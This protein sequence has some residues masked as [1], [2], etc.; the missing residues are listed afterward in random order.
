MANKPFEIQSST[1][2][3]G[4]VDLQAGET[5]IVI[6]GVT[7]ASTYS[8]DE[9]NE[10]G[11]Q[12]RIFDVP[13]VVIDAVNYNI[14]DNGDTPSNLATYE[15]PEIDNDGHIDS[16]DVVT[17]GTA[18]TSVQSTANE[19][20]NMYAYIG[21]D[22]YPNMFTS[23]V[24]GDWAQIPFRPKMRPNAIENI[25]GG[26]ESSI[27]N[28]TS[29]VDI[30]VSD[31]S[32]IVSADGTEWTFDTNGN[33][34]VPNSGA[35]LSDNSVDGV[36]FSLTNTDFVANKYI[37]VR[38]GTNENYSHLH[39]DSGDNLNYDVFLGDDDKFVKVDHTGS[40]DIQAQLETT[41]TA[42]D[43]R[44]WYNIF[45]DFAQIDPS[46]IINGSVTYD[47][48]GYTYV[49]GST[50]SND[51]SEGNHL[52]LKYSP[53]G[54]LI[55]RKTWT[56]NAGMP[57]GSYNASMRYMPATVSTY[58][59][60]AVASYAWLDI[61][62]YIGT[63]DTDGN[64]VDLTGTPRAP[65]RI[66][67][68]KITDIEADASTDSAAISGQFEGPMIAGIDFNNI[69]SPL[70]AVFAPDDI[71]N[72][73]Y[74]KSIVNNDSVFYAAVGSYYAQSNYYKCI[75]GTVTFAPPSLTTALY[76][77]GTN[78]TTSNLRGEDI[79]KD[80]SGN[81]YVVING[82]DTPPD[83]IIVA[84]TNINN[85]GVSRWQKKISHAYN[86]R[87]TGLVYH[88]GFV[89]LTAEHST[90]SNNEIVLLKL[91]VLTGDCVWSRTFS[92]PNDLA[93]G[94]GYGDNSSSD[95]IV[96]PTGKYITI[97]FAITIDGNN[98]NLTVQY[99]L[100]GELTGT[101]ASGGSDE[102]TIS[103]SSFTF[104]F[105]DHDL[106]LVDI[107]ATTT[108]TNP[109]LTITSASLIATAVTV[110]GGW[111]NDYVPLT[112]RSSTWT[113]DADG[114][115]TPPIMSQV[116]YRNNYGLEG[117]TLQISND[118]ANQV[119]ITGPKPTVDYPAARRIV[120]QGRKG[121]DNTDDS[122][123]L[124]PNPGEGG[125]VY[126]WGGTGGEGVLT[127]GVYAGGSGGDI[128][129]RGGQGQGT[130]AGGYVRI[131]GGYSDQGNGG[132]I[133]ITAGNCTVDYI[134]DSN[135]GSNIG[136]GGDVNIRA[137]YREEYYPA[138]GDDGAVNVYTGQSHTNQWVFNP[139]GS[140]TFPDATVQTTAWAGEKTN[141]W[142]QDFSTYTYHDVPVVATSTEYATNGDI[143]ALF[144]HQIDTTTSSYTSLARF[145]ANGTQVW[146]M[147]FTI[148]TYTNGWGLAVDNANGFVYVAGSISTTG[149]YPVLTK[150]NQT[151]GVVVWSKSYDYGDIGIGWVVDVDTSGN[152][153]M[154]GFVDN[155]TDNS[156]VT[157]KINPADGTVTWS[158]TLDGQQND[159][160]YGMGVGPSSEIVVVGYAAN[161]GNFTNEVTALYAESAQ[162][163]RWANASGTVTAGGVT[164]NY[165]VDTVGIP[166]F[167][168]S[169]DATGDWT[170]GNTVTTILGTSFGVLSPD[171]DM[172][173]KV[174]AVSGADAGT[175]VAKYQSNG[176]LLWQKFILNRSSGSNCSGADADIDQYG[177]VY[178]CGTYGG[179]SGSSMY[180]SKF[181][182]NG[183]KLW[184]QIVD[185]TCD[186]ITCSIVVGDDNYLYMSGTVDPSSTSMF[187]GKFDE[188]GNVVWQRIL[189]NNSDTGS[190]NWQYNSGSNIAV[191]NG[192]I[193]IGG[194]VF[195]GTLGALVVQLDT[196]GNVW[197]AGDYQWLAGSLSIS[198]YTPTVYDARKTSSTATPN[199]TTQTPT[200]EVSIF[201]LGRL[202]SNAD[203]AGV[204]RAF[205]D[206]GNQSNT[207]NASHNGQFI[208]YS[209]GE[210][211]S[212]LV[213]PN[214]SATQL[215]IGYT[216]SLVV[217]NFNNG[218]IYVNTD[219]DVSNGLIINA[220]GYSYNFG[221]EGGNHND[222][223]ISGGSGGNTEIYTLLKV[224]TNRW[225][226][227]GPSIVDNW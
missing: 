127:N 108:V 175:I 94:A 181:D 179:F 131:E 143:F 204:R 98:K 53:N 68:V 63:M 1:L 39:I 220:A 81:L 124:S 218:Y 31:G 66:A 91:D 176:T 90:S 206:P 151:T 224:D 55:W 82:N 24:T 59:S 83:Y 54:T 186:D 115:L 122:D 167:T 89:Y 171:D 217:D 111:Q 71:D 154:V 73:G 107:T 75:L 116:G 5:T 96:D 137:G 119:I 106:T 178:V 207:L 74:F 141:Q 50:V 150:I 6:P 99:P 52:Y 159:E 146:S 132:F 192:Y 223:R 7:Q 219:G 47:A 180:L 215:P 37:T 210:S 22:T 222:W 65:L 28:G 25:G 13:P 135:P 197:S 128:K 126:L 165:T 20:T 145:T 201:L 182:I 185:G 29:S 213:V 209:G 64:L 86:L 97:S 36:K 102:L 129:L 138:T 26:S 100:D 92:S 15:V 123:W 42:E 101:F 160:A 34:T 169:A 33:L 189:T 21:T 155:G 9:V 18:Y 134:N 40:V 80:P 212:T 183:N 139:D 112:A 110:G 125:D 38:G 190:A 164:F 191:K 45:G 3:V 43:R 72:D 163:I 88:A 109:A 56:D 14:Y 11:N 148:E 216:V 130:G 205:T 156:I 19:S 188:A 118:P 225:I 16:I 87:G 200:E 193:A 172:V 60:I 162:N 95:S 76:G 211:G 208:Y 30:P 199:V 23:W 166:T 136:Q 61:I 2:R 149:P 48:A 194:G 4:G 203:F 170:V 58:E 117:R 121:F 187:A 62:S 85:V 44:P 32:I 104:T 105:A 168:V 84:S 113:F 114:S 147:K 158:K 78:Y 174:G 35:I 196:S 221:G 195:S 93:F 214:N 142:V 152:P 120:I 51:Y 79:C 10:A 8:A 133:D 77:I 153:I 184:T 226:L 227:S 173:V 67:D 17:A 157:A 69:Q 41:I 12:S 27:F 49:L 103:N 161:I 144:K 70:V 140:L 177:N 198:G 202:T 46:F 57:C